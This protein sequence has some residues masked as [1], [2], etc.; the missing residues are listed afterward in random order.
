MLRILKSVIKDGDE[1]IST[2]CGSILFEKGY[3]YQP[4]VII[5]PGIS[6]LMYIART[7]RPDLTDHFFKVSYGIRK[8]FSLLRPFHG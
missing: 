3:D 5:E 4:Y 7:Q 2:Y 6:V 1:G 8:F